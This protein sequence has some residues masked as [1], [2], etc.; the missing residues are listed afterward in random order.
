[1]KKSK[2][3]QGYWNTI[4]HQ[5]F[6]TITQ[7]LELAAVEEKDTRKQCR[8]SFFTQDANDYRVNKYFWSLVDIQ[9]VY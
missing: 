1:M 2:Q 7:S 5:S 6:T 3:L 4:V 8:E 9:T